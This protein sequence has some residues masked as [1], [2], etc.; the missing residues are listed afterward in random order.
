[1]RRNIMSEAQ[2][3][4]V[5]L[6]LILSLTMASIGMVFYFGQGSIEALEGDIDS[7]DINNDFAMLDSAMA[8]SVLGDSERQRTEVSLRG[9]TVASEPKDSWFRVEFDNDSDPNDYEL[10]NATIGKIEY[11]SQDGSRVAYEG[12][13]VWRTSEDSNSSVM[14]SPP[15]FHYRDL[16]LTLPLFNITSYRNV[17][18]EKDS[19]SVRSTDTKVIYPQGNDDNPLEP[20]DLNITVKSDYYNA[21]AKFFEERTV[22]TNVRTDSTENTASMQLPVPE[23]G[24]IKQA[25]Y[26]GGNNMVIEEHSDV[27]SYSDGEHDA[28][29]DNPVDPSTYD[30]E[31]DE[32]NAD[33]AAA[34]DITA[35][36]GACVY[37]DIRG[38]E[39]TADGVEID[40]VYVGGDV[41]SGRHAD[42]LENGHVA[43]S[44]YATHS[45]EL[46]DAYNSG[47]VSVAGDIH[48]SGGKNQV[49]IVESTVA[50]D[51]YT[52]AEVT[53][54][55]DGVVQ[56]NIYAEKSVT[57]KE[58]AKVTGD[59]I[60]SN[61]KVECNE[62]A[63]VS[64]DTIYADKT[65][66]VDSECEDNG[67]D[68]Q[69]GPSLVSPDPPKFFDVNHPEPSIP[70]LSGDA[71]TEDENCGASDKEIL[72]LEDDTCT[73]SEGD[74]DVD[75]VFVEEDGELEIDGSVNITV[76][77]KDGFEV[78][79]GGEV[80]VEGEL[81]VHTEEDVY[82]DG[83]VETDVD[84]DGD[85]TG[86][87]HVSKQIQI[88]VAGG[89]PDVY[90]GEHAD[91][92]GVLYAPGING[93]ESEEGGD[94]YGA[95][96]TGQNP[97]IDSR[98][99]YDSDLDGLDISASF[100]QVYYL[101]ITENKVEL[102]E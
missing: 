13:G 66:Q 32:D 70:S 12:G 82:I 16:T 4:V 73:V 17:G 56:G 24:E 54:G 28:D 43:G 25:V 81:T 90:V 37:G 18:G 14:I 96:I 5:G 30:C 8:N 58:D 22:G 79:E 3:E 27:D 65:N 62:D 61:G 15:E 85:G 99:H 63:N 39:S 78:E 26:G 53:L 44:I 68:V 19:F 2:S 74:Y 59:E 86:E 71:P 1:M 45:I 100:S 36:E 33:V 52:E 69:R 9:G 83:L 42:V 29:K 93:V 89:N 31:W 98:V 80:E 35:D 64:V 77:G 95:I 11:L 60:H 51:V 49:S 91:F 46:D 101:H 94:I 92:T 6:I 21:W 72:A 7:E 88:N 84:D 55:E 76:G 48:H 40:T 87:P 10:I 97:E 102:M 67:A 57:L 38:T 34:G 41:H 23:P 20:G 47:D 75:K 50:G